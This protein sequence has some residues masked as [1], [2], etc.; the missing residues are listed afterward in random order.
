MLFRDTGI[1]GRGDPDLT[2]DYALVRLYTVKI[3]VRFFF[4]IKVGLLVSKLIF[5]LVV[6]NGLAVIHS[7]SAQWIEAEGECY[8]VNI[9]PEEARQ[10]A[11]SAA[12]ADAIQKAVGVKVSEE[13]FSNVSEA[14]TGTNASEFNDFFSKFNR[15][16]SYGRIIEE[17]ITNLPPVFN[18]DIPVYRVKLR[19]KV[20]DEKGKPDPGFKAEI[21]LKNPVLYDRGNPLANDIIDFKLWA[22]KDC[23]LYLFNIMS[24]DSVQ[25]VFPN[26][27]IS[28]NYYSAAAQQQEFEKQMKMINLTFYASL[29][30]GKNIAVEGLMLIALKEKIDFSSPNL[31]RDGQNIIPTYKGA[32]T[33]IMNWLVRIEMEKRTEAFAA[34][35]IRRKTSP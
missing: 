34:F 2:F 23:Y 4:K 32:L 19:A 7:Q 8:A 6:L 14:L 18:N 25:L 20:A 27:Y 9:T 35:E 13:T 11:L 1:R 17:E 5:F 30:T 33:D 16:S 15:T 3:I 29:P 28:N 12:R 10:K 22:S 31:S 24:N 21:I 26:K